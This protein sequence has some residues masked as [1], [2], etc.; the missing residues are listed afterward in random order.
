MPETW[1]QSLGWED[2]LV[3]EMDTH[4]SILAWRIPWTGSLGDNSLW[5]HKELEMT[6]WL[7]FPLFHR[8]SA[9]FLF[10]VPEILIIIQCEFPEFNDL[11]GIMIIFSENAMAPHSSVLALRIPG[12]GS[13]RVRHDWSDL[14]AAAR[15]YF[16]NFFV[17]NTQQCIGVR[18]HY[19]SNLLSVDSG[20]K[21]P[22]TVFAN[23]P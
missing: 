3:K 4:F 1:V 19:V 13:H 14:A 21:V 5:G 8:T 17:E 12:M 16:K 10:V 20:E 9:T 15:L 2:P 6:E 22:W 23:S 11:D 18:G 7:T